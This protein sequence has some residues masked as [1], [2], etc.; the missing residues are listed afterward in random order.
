MNKAKATR[1][2]DTTDSIVRNALAVKPDATR[3]EKKTQALYGEVFKAAAAGAPRSKESIAEAA[4]YLTGGKFSQVFGG[5]ATEKNK[6]STKPES[7]KGE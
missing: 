7:P 1:V 5:S 6:I 3:A 4:N 2:P